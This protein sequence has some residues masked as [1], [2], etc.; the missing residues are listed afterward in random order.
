MTNY[1]LPKNFNLIQFDELDSTMTTLKKLAFED[2]KIGTIV[3]AKKQ[4]QGRG[5]HG[6]EWC[7]P[8]GNLYFSFLRSAEKHNSDETFAP[9]FIVSIALAKTILALSDNVDL[10]LKWPNDVLIGDSKVAGILIESFKNDKNISLL[11]VGIGVNIVSN[12]SNTI[13]PSTNLMKEGLLVSPDDVLNC[14]FNCLNLIENI[15]VNKGIK[16]LFKMWHEY[17]Y[18]I[19]TKMSVKI[20]KNRNEGTYNGIDEKGSLLLLK[21]NGEE[22]KILAGEI[23]VL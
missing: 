10:K 13:Y 16:E 14:F 5:R 17:S 11:N 8:E 3:L 18:S 7:S 15:L 6:R 9:V 2:A 20:G 1:Q 12:P 4:N 23:F 21:D 19:G 22:I